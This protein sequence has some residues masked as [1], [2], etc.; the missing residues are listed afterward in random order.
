[1]DVGG[2]TLGELNL[3]DEQDVAERGR[4]SI[5]AE[6]V[7]DAAAVGVADD[8]VTLRPVLHLLMAVEGRGQDGVRVTCQHRQQREQQQARAETRYTE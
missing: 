5:D 7:R 6:H 2:H 8:A 3:V 4:I 1:V